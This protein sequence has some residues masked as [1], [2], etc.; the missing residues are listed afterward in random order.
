MT[1]TPPASTPTRPTPHE[2]PPGGLHHAPPRRYYHAHVILRRKRLLRGGIVEVSLSGKLFRALGWSRGTRLGISV[3]QGALLI[4][5]VES[6]GQCASSH[7]TTRWLL[8][9]PVWLWPSAQ[10]LTIGLGVEPKFQMWLGD[11]KHLSV[12]KLTIEPLTLA[13][14]N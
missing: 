5:P 4:C 8:T 10:C 11:N 14:G 6:G 9:F 7:H 12:G 3:K 2:G 13:Q 1:P